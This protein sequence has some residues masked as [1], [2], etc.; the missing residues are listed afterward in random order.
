MH[1]VGAGLC[2]Y[3]LPRKKVTSIWIS[4]VPS[5]DGRYSMATSCK[6]DTPVSGGA[7]PDA[8]EVTIVWNDI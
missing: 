8:R 1:P 6:F 3:N 5:I 7:H 2:S 4:N